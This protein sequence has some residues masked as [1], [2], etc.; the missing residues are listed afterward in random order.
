[1]SAGESEVMNDNTMSVTPT[2]L[3]HI[4]HSLWALT[5]D[6][7]SDSE[8]QSGRAASTFSTPAPGGRVAPGVMAMTCKERAPRLKLLLQ[9]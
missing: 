5:P 4:P 7:R 9:N 6:D 8:E 3:S 2:N 1:M